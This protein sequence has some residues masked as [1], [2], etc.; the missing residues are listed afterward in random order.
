MAPFAHGA[1]TASKPTD[2]TGV[3]LTAPQVVSACWRQGDHPQ[4]EWT[5]IDAL[6]GW[7]APVAPGCAPPPAPSLE[8]ASLPVAIVAGADAKPRRSL[9]HAHQRERG[10]GQVTFQW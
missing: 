3:T 6:D 9:S 10:R 5:R 4:H 7:S 8:L 2:Q 1:I